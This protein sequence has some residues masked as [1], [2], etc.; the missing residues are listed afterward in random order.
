M[1]LTLAFPA[2]AAPMSDVPGL[3]VLARI[4]EETDL[5]DGVRIAG[6]LVPVPSGHGRLVTT[7]LADALHARYFRGDG[8]GPSAPKVRGEDRTVGAE[9]PVAG[10]RGYDFCRRLADT[11]RPDLFRRA[12]WRFTYRIS[13]GSPSFVVTLGSAARDTASCFLHLQPGTAPEVFARLVTALD[14]YGL[15]FRA[16]L[17]GD[18]AGCIRTDTAVVTVDRSA[19]SALARLALRMQQR[20][21]FALA[22]S[23]PAFTRQ[24]AP[25]VALAD[26]PGPDSPF[27][28]HRCRL[29]A[30]GLVA[31]GHGAGPAARRAAVLRTLTAAGLDPVALHLNPGSRDVDLRR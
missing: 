29:V 11:L 14:G 16:E 21:P 26:E 20:A 17:A 1:P 3:A 2:P 15:D 31:A 6:E 12:G 9:S 5:D 19:A 24:L 27:G 25:G 10:R 4:A 23:V 13:A 7:A 22:P 8:P 28:R 18:P 30:A